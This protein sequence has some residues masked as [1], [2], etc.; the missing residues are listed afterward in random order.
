MKASKFVLVAVLIFLCL[1]HPALCAPQY[2]PEEVSRILSAQEVERLKREKAQ[3]VSKDG[4]YSLNGSFDRQADPF[5]A[6]PPIMPSKEP[7]AKQKAPAEKM[8]DE[9]EE[10]LSAANRYIRNNKIFVVLLLLLIVNSAHLWTVHR[11]RMK[12][13]Q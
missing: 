5:G 11:G 9:I 12:T 10:L 7:P 6:R 4:S 13:K 1:Q 8:L 2:T 3:P